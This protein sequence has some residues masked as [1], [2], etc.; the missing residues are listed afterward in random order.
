MKNLIRI[1]LALLASLMLFA[2]FARAS[3]TKLTI[4]QKG[5][6]CLMPEDDP[7]VEGF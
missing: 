6:V 1:L 4:D 7:P 5:V 2:G 3:V